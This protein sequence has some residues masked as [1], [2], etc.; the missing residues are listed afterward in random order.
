MQNQRKEESDNFQQVLQKLT[1]AQANSERLH[2]ESYSRM[3]NLLCQVLNQHTPPKAANNGYQAEDE[4]MEY[5][6]ES[7][8]NQSI[9]IDFTDDN[10]SE[11]SDNMPPAET[12]TQ[13]PSPNNN[14]TSNKTARTPPGPS[15]IE[16][17]SKKGRSVGGISSGDIRRQLQFEA[18]GKETKKPSDD[19]PQQ[20]SDE[21]SQSKLDDLNDRAPTGGGPDQE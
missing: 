17:P 14:S 13:A 7:E 18:P 9:E 19:D 8:E 6:E 10:A 20:S 1:S 21:D 12:P 5:K 4:E 3:E 16:K 2:Q 15:S 11:D